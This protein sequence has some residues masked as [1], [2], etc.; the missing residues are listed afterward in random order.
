MWEK[1][2]TF[3][4]SHIDFLST[5]I[6][7]HDTSYETFR[8]EKSGDNSTNPEDRTGTMFVGFLLSSSG[9]CWPNA[10]EHVH[11]KEVNKIEERE[12]RVKE[13]NGN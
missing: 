9:N 3:Y 13:T 11:P 2:N 6:A 5:N 1:Q 4:V 8:S 7:K 10:R 12:E